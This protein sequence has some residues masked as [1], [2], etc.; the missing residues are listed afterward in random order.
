MQKENLGLKKTLAEKIWFENKRGIRKANLAFGMTQEELTEYAKCK[1]SVKYFS[2]AY[3]KIKKEDGTIGQM[4]LRDYQKDIIDLYTN[5]RFSILCASR[6][7]GKTVSAAIVLLHFAL[8]NSNKGIM[9]VANKGNTVKEIVRKIKDIYQYLPFFLKKGVLTWNEKAITFDNGCRIQSENR[10]A[11]PSIG[12]TID[13]LYLDE[14]AKIPNNIIEAY[15]GAVVPTVSSIENSKIIITSTPE[16]FNLFHKLLTDA[17]RDD[18][19]P[20]KNPY[21]A[22]RVYWW[23]L[24]ERKNTRLL[25]L[26]YRLKEHG[27]SEEDIKNFL[28]NE[29]GYKI[30]DKSFDN[31][32]YIMVSNLDT[33]STSISFLRTLRI[34]NIPLVEL[35][36][37]T[38]WK[39]QETKLIGSEEMFNQEYDLQFVTGDK[40]LFDSD[41]MSRM[42]Q[43]CA[44][45]DNID[46]PEINK[47]I[48][49]PYTK[50]KWL[51]GMPVIFN[52]D[53]MKKY[54]IFASVD[55]GEGLGGDYSVI[56]IFRLM[57]KNKD[58]IDKFHDKYKSVYEYFY[59]E[60]IGMFRVNHWS[61]EE[62][63][64]LFY[65]IFFD[66][67]DSEKCKVVLEYN[68]YG[69]EFI[70]VLPHVFNEQNIYSSGIFLRYKHRAEDQM[71]KIGLKITIGEND[72]SKKMLIKNF[73]D[74][75]KKSLMH[76]YNDVN[77]NEL[78]MFVKKETNAGNFTFS[79]E[80]GNDDTVM[81]AINLSSVFS[82]VHYKSMVEDLLATLPNDMR[83]LIEK[84]AFGEDNRNSAP[85]LAPFGSNFRKV[86]KN[87]GQQQYGNINGGM[88]S[89]ALNDMYR[90]F[91][92]NPTGYR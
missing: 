28:V 91:G 65:V 68:K 79:A 21:K 30:Y 92:T 35:C 72:S 67:F 23:Q 80:S 29:N 59:L 43:G 86:Y 24:K 18:E 5:N 46:F 7:V 20:M 37:I 16:G 83:I 69:G 34:N 61:I 45:F 63:A 15:Y 11:S 1:Y 76:F 77:I 88:S 78:S 8:F 42:K 66:L 14:F 81:S 82:H 58:D 71:A 75:V 87:N 70:G 50:L 64:E 47:K 13:L 19:D 22:M 32:K 33:D 73:Q 60:Q 85:S 41:T 36:I 90:H 38:N 54:H 26:A 2:E 9:I 51:S 74:S 6:Q 53:D 40:L 84:Y 31:K 44:L 52:K 89:S 56:N 49:L 10:T 55:L 39:E 4:T 27:I 17:E 12:F 48:K 3:C 62:L 57:P 25:P